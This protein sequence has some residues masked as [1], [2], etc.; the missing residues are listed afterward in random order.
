MN[1]INRVVGAWHVLRG[2]NP[3]MSSKIG[4]PLR[5][6][7][8]PRRYFDTLMSY[9]L[10]NALYTETMMVLRQLQIASEPL[11]AL[12]N[13]AYRAV[14]FYAMTVWPGTLPKALPIASENA[15]L[16][17][18]IAQLYGWSNWGEQ[19]QTFIRNLAAYGSMFLKVAQRSDG[20]PYMQ[21]IEPQY[22][23]EFEEDERKF[24]TMVRIDTP[25]TEGAGASL[26][27]RTRSE[28][29][30]KADQ[31]MRIYEHDK[32]D[33]PIDQLPDPTQVISLDEFGIDFVP[34]VHAKLRTAGGRWGLGAFVP[35]LDKIDEANRITTRLHQMLFRNKP[36]WAVNGGGNDAA[37]RPLPAPKVGESKTGRPEDG[38]IIRI[39]DE[40][41]YRLPGNA[42]L[43][44]LVPP[45]NYSAF[46]DAIRDQM[47]EIEQDLPELAYFRM[48]D[49]ATTSGAHAQ[50]LLTDAIARASEARGNAETALIQAQTMAL[51]IGEKAG[52]FAES[53]GTFEGGDFEHTFAERE[54]IPLGEA[55]RLKNIDSRRTLG[56]SKRQALIEAGYSTA[57]IDEMAV[58]SESD[59]AD[60]LDN[61]R[62]V[63]TRR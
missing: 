51:T 31:T 53:V 27:G 43:K 44:T 29:W 41:F 10:N 38:D 33:A 37:G 17:P 5:P 54:I 45:L 50:V 4:D 11:K 58:E 60:A 18:A 28:V 48:R 56:I 6:E 42:D 47:K 21:P 8:N 13:P 7:A 46:I 52:A 3:P 36:S 39:A 26:R 22:V 9:Y 63:L 35:A 34:V 49:L 1:L 12:R 15:R 23:P 25:I 40:P 61:A 57:K 59:T 30:S 62:T 20:R 16:A 32:G 24:L 19:K 2:R 55:E 14:E